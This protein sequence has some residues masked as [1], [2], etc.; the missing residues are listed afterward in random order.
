MLVRP[1]FAEPPAGRQTLESFLESCRQQ[2][3]RSRA[4]RYASVS[5]EGGDL[6]PLAILQQL[7]RADRLSFYH[8]N[9][10]EDL[11]IAA[12]DSVASFES[13][14]LDRFKAARQFS[15]R[16]FEN[17]SHWNPRS[18]PYGNPHLFCGFTFFERDRQGTFPSSTVFLPHWQIVRHASGAT[19]VCNAIVR[20]STD[21]AGLARAL[22]SE[23]DELMRSPVRV[24]EATASRERQ[25]DRHNI[26][27][28]K[29]TVAEV[30]ETIAGGTLSKAVL[31]H[32]VDLTA[33][34]D[35][36]AISSLQS[37]RHRYADCHLF[38]M[39]NR[40]GQRFIGASPERLF[41]IRQ[42]RLVADALAGSAPRGATPES[43]AA[44]AEA[45]L[46]SPKEMREHRVVVEFLLDRLRELGI[47]PEP[48]APTRLL[49]LS[50]IQHLWTP[51][52][53]DLTGL[54][55]PEKRVGEA[56]FTD[57]ADFADL[58]VHPLQLVESL[59]PTPAVAG[60]PQSVAY[61]EICRHEQF[62]RLLFAAPL[63]W[64]DA[65]GN[66]SFLVGIRSALLD[67]ARARLYAG[68]GIV[69]GSHPDR[70]LAE[71]ELKLRTTIDSLV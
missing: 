30:L 50:N 10:A 24:A 25:I 9:T 19:M 2:A 21:A 65:A 27:R 48:I 31:S 12:I 42:G 23:A 6:D 1:S 44:H 55:D 17:I 51:I 61:R 40:W 68:A 46:A 53:A 4:E 33:P 64:F 67:G 28:F 56:D 58:A 43:D 71:V 57:L 7:D 16:C 45:L 62:D 35:F 34:Q 69:A 41:A 37:L 36:D 63:G 70:E 20:G 52:Y 66:A 59:H 49:Q 18:L 29:A 38:A 47:E 22:Q 13:D 32:A 8:E 3:E 15:E 11:M 39:G 60:S 5:F 14:C 26:A 54:A